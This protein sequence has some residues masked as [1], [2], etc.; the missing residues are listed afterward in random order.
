MPLS[1]VQRSSPPSENSSIGPPT[2]FSIP[3]TR[4]NDEN[5]K[6]WKCANCRCDTYHLGA[7][8]SDRRSP[9][10]GAASFAWIPGTLAL[11]TCRKVS[12]YTG[13]K[14]NL[15]LPCRNHVES[16]S[17]T[18]DS[19]CCKEKPQT[20]SMSTPIRR[21]K[22]LTTWSKALSAQRA[23]RSPA[24][25]CL[26]IV[27]RST[28]PGNRRDPPSRRAL[29]RVNAQETPN[30]FTRS[31]SFCGPNTARGSVEQDVL[32][33]VK[34]QVKRHTWT[35]HRKGRPP[36]ARTIPINVCTWSR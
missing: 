16:T 36:T 13:L 32:R 4:W 15:A 24:A 25:S 6:R 23:G 27:Q 26:A 5:K 2:R 30:I 35:T 28:S 20:T 7:A 8:V 3:Q 11:G 22:F 18:R 34:T 29:P 31:A 9:A 33:C 19:E 17:K 14:W 10:A 21:W 1:S 12:K